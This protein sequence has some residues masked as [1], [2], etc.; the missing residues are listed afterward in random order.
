MFRGLALQ[1]PFIVHRNLMNHYWLRYLNCFSLKCVCFWPPSPIS[2][3]YTMFHPISLSLS[4]SL[5]LY[6]TLT[7]PPHTW[8]LHPEA[9]K[10]CCSPKTYPLMTFLII[11]PTYSSHCPTQN[12]CWQ[13][14]PHNLVHLPHMHIQTHWHTK[15]LPSIW[16]DIYIYLRNLAKPRMHNHLNSD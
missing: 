8:S 4:L 13:W 3:P 15:T 16:S 5:S 12:A 11:L 14:G 1:R 9:A 7:A 10:V 6:L 2:Y